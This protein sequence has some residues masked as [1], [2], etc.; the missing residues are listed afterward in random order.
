MHARFTMIAAAALMLAATAVAPAGRMR[1][2]GGE[3]A[4]EFAPRPVHP[5]IGRSCREPGATDAG[6]APPK[7]QR[8]ARITTC[9]CGG[10]PQPKSTTRGRNKRAQ[11]R[12][13]ELFRLGDLLLGPDHRN[14]AVADRCER[15]PVERVRRVRVVHQLALGHAHRGHRRRPRRRREQAGDQPLG[16]VVIVRHRPVA[17]NDQPPAGADERAHQ[18]VE[19]NV[20]AGPEPRLLG[21]RGARLAGGVAGREDDQV[22]VE[23]QVENLAEGQQAVR[24]AAAEARQ[25]GRLGGTFRRAAR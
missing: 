24:A 18:P 12:A 1:R 22:G 7:R 6:Q 2:R 25:Q 9:R 21:R 10:E 5:R 19:R 16:R 13:G 23:M 14:V 17:G 15:R 3:S 4:V 8:A 20:A 11:L